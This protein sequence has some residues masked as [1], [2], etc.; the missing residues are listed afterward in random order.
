MNILELRKSILENDEDSSLDT[1]FKHMINYDVFKQ[2]MNCDDIINQIYVEKIQ[3]HNYVPKYWYPQITQVN[4]PQGRY[5]TIDSLPH[6]IPSVT[7]ILSKTKDDTHLIAW[8]NKV[9]NDE[10]DRIVKESSDI[11]SVFH[12]NIEKYLKFKDT[13]DDVAQNEYD[14]N[15]FKIAR[16]LAN[17]VIVNGLDKKLTEI[18]ALEEY[19]F[20][21]YFWAGTA[22]CIGIYNGK[23]SIIDFKNTRK[24]KKREWIEDYFCQ[25]A[26]YREAHNKLF[27]TNIQQGVI[28]MVDRNG[29][30]EPF[31]IEGNE[32]DS[33]TDKWLQR[34]EQ[35]YKQL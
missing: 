27:G 33:Y 30:F 10:A 15:I 6:K 14:D 7:T 8:K 28:L 5:Y 12:N 22:D 25:L 11:G 24:M 4:S 3:E 20:Y 34:V 32:F 23:E 17:S 19:L 29:N 35:Y 9:G 26:A 1:Y 21:P 18:W 16:R 31:I 13:R 2:S